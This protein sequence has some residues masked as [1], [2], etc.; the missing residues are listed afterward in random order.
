MDTIEWQRERFNKIKR[1]ME[2]IAEKIGIKLISTIPI[3]SSANQNIF[4]NI[5]KPVFMEDN[6]IK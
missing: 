5:N 2:K 1:T 4:T 3:S 6:L